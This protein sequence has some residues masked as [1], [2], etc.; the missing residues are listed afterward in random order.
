M[1]PS[2]TIRFRW[3]FDELLQAHRSHFH[4]LPRHAFKCDTDYERVVELARGRVR[5]F[6]DVT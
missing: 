1:E 6:H 2:T 3:T 4:R 5:R